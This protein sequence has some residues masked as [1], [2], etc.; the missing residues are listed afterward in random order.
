MTSHFM[1]YYNGCGKTMM[2]NEGRGEGRASL[3]TALTEADV[4]EAALAWLMHGRDIAATL[5]IR[6]L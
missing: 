5:R 2:H 4:E 3:M 6:P 1:M